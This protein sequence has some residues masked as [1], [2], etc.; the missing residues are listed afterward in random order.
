MT[1]D[2][3]IKQLKA[4]LR[5]TK[6]SCCFCKNVPLTDSEKV[7]VGYLKQILPILEDKNA[8]LAMYEN[9]EHQLFFHAHKLSTIP[10]ENSREIALLTVPAGCTSVF[11]VQDDGHLSLFISSLFNYSNAQNSSWFS[12]LCDCLDSLVKDAKFTVSDE[13]TIDGL[14]THWT[15]AAGG[16]HSIRRSSRNATEHPNATP[17][18]IQVKRESDQPETFRNRSGTT[19]K[20]SI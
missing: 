11:T 5:L 12:D 19:P 15:T 6:H 20:G 16:A 14:A 1:R 18:E 17:I 9:N 2:E 4:A 8:Q 3:C 7:I 10:E 13:N